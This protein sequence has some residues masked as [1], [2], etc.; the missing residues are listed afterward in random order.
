MFCKNISVSFSKT[1]LKYLGIKT[2]SLRMEVLNCG[3][4]TLA[5]EQGKSQRRLL[6]LPV[7]REKNDRAICGHSALLEYLQLP[8]RLH[9]LHPPRMIINFS[10][11]SLNECQQEI[12]FQSPWEVSPPFPC[13]KLESLEEPPSRQW[14]PEGWTS[15][16]NT[17][18]AWNTC[19]PKATGQ[20]FPGRCAQKCGQR[21]GSLWY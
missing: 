17:T 16:R 11:M 14:R 10:E 1:Y 8:A 21:Q 5:R 9:L 18:R 19:C 4:E 2:E 7:F 13:W 6:L 20:I 3:P 15:R 12:V